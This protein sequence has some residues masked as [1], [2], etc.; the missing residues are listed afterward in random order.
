MKRQLKYL[1]SQRLYELKNFQ[2]NRKGFWEDFD[3]VLKNED[4]LISKLKYLNEKYPTLVNDDVTFRDKLVDLHNLQK[5][6]KRYSF[7]NWI[8]MWL[9]FLTGYNGLM[10]KMQID[11]IKQFMFNQKVTLYRGIPVRKKWDGNKYVMDWE[12]APKL[13]SGYFSF[14]FKKNIAFAFTQP[15]WA[16]VVN[17]F[18]PMKNKIERNGYLYELNILPKDIH[19]VKNEGG[20]YEALLK[21]PLTGYK[22]HIVKEG[23][24]V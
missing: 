1:K 10:K 11:N 20:E 23:E 12:N 8:Y 19:I 21:G 4:G 9:N 5:I 13:D 14:S 24:I 6:P 3:Y 17:Y 16:H 22:V 7:S 2:E 15:E 18:N